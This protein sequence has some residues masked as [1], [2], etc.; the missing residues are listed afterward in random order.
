MR[1][2]AFTNFVDARDQQGKFRE[3]AI[4]AVRRNFYI[5]DRLTSKQSSD[6]ATGLVKDVI[7]ILATGRFRLT[8]W[9]YNSREVLI[10]IPSSEVAHDIIHLDRN[11]WPQEKDLGI[12][13]CAGQDLLSLEP[14]KSEFP[15]TK[16][17][18]FDSMSRAACL[19]P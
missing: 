6:E 7:G 12:K 14:V 9:M 17:G 15:N 13:W 18:I 10:A 8:K 4:N 1:D 19:I 16:R 11:E 5:Y 2:R 3:D